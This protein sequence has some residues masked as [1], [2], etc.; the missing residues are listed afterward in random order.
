MYDV[1]KKDHNLAMYN[2]YT[3]AKTLS[4]FEWYELPETIPA[5]ELE[6][7]LQKHGFAFI[8]KV[9][10]KLYAFWGGIGGEQDVYGNPTKITI[11]NVALKFNKTLDIK[12][13]G[14][15]VYNDDCM[16][17]VL[18]LVSRFNSS[19]VENDISLYMVGI[20]SRM[21]TLL[22]ASDDKTKTSADNYVQKLIDG[23]V[24][25]IGEAAL[26]DG[27][28]RQ[29][30]TSNNGSA[31]T[32]LIEFHQYIKGS[33]HNELGLQS[34]FNMKRERL[35]SGEVESGEDALYPFVDN[36][37]KCRLEA[38]KKINAMYSTS[39][40]VDYGG[41]WNVKQ[42]ELVDGVINEPSNENSGGGVSNESSNESPSESLTN[43]GEESSN[44]SG[45]ESTKYL[46]DETQETESLPKPT[47]REELPKLEAETLASQIEE[48]EAMLEDET[49]SDEDTEV[50]NALLNELKGGE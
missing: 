32:S 8:T 43:L 3:L 25:V 35:T 40:D 14:V 29:D 23:D 5:F 46:S 18:P 19:L 9:E 36:M 11:N 37:M 24:S 41:V 10:G 33:L 12:A 22:S 50:L 20:N 38:V 15:L 4:M 42:K 16:N 31:F 49:L 7:L 28:K 26:F 13:D 2:N 39:I 34:N 27:I 48:A 47:P 6:K 17:G 44:E 1:K 21:Q 45:K 30:A